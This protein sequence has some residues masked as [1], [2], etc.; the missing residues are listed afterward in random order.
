MKLNYIVLVV[1]ISIFVSRSLANEE[2]AENEEKPSDVVE[3]SAA[4]FD[5]KTK[6]GYW[7][8]EFFA[9]WCGHCKKL[10]PIWEDLATKSKGNFNVAKVDC[11]VEKD[12]CSKY[13]VRGYPTVKLFV[14]GQP[15]DFKGQRN[16]EAFTKFVEDAKIQ[17]KEPVAPNQEP[18]KQEPPKQEPPKQEQEHPKPATDAPTGV[19]GSPNT[20]G[21]VIILEDANFASNI[22]EG[23]WLVKFYAPWCGHCKRLAPTWSELATSSKGKFNVAKVDCTVEKNVCAQYGVRGYPTVKFF[24]GAQPIDYNGARTIDDFTKFVEKYSQAVQGSTRDEL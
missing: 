21:D 7:L 13:G 16:I 6:E 22:A 12:V 20:E 14:N 4:T 9:P 24:K 17:K 1:V 8:T 11:T 19:P 18:P 2:P 10:A 23:E 5:E 15:E 3:L